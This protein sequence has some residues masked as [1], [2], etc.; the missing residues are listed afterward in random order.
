MASVLRTEWK[1]DESFSL[2]LFHRGGWCL[3]LVAD[4]T[5]ENRNEYPAFSAIRIWG[6]PVADL[7]CLLLLWSH[8]KM[9]R[10]LVSIHLSVIQN[11]RPSRSLH[12]A[13]ALLSL[14]GRG[15]IEKHRM[16]CT[17]RSGKMCS[18]CSAFLLSHHHCWHVVR[19][20]HKH[21]ICPCDADGT[22]QA[23]VFRARAW[24]GPWKW[25][26]ARCL[27]VTLDHKTENR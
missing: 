1:Y 10:F 22:L 21:Y 24:C 9:W 8:N 2:I 26:R 13:A 6:K 27:C 19:S 17:Y 5:P 23:H 15:C 4:S 3:S 12:P 18:V 7:Y 14:K 20:E 16:Q 11:P 25:G